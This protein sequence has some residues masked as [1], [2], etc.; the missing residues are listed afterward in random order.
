MKVKAS[1]AGALML[2]AGLFLSIAG[3]SPAKAA[4][5]ESAAASK[6]ESATSEKSTKSSSR[7]LKKKRHAY[8]K[9]PRTAVQT[10]RE[11]KELG[12]ARCRGAAGDVGIGRQRLR[13]DEF[14]RRGAGRHRGQ[15]QGD[16]TGDV[17]EGQHDPA[18]GGET[19]RPTG[20]PRPRVRRWPP[21]ISSTT[22]TRSCRRA[23]PPRPPTSQTVASQTSCLA[24]GGDGT[25]Q[26]GAAG[27]LRSGIQQ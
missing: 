8:R 22:S 3:P 13:A 5:S 27:K 19:I 21:R 12:N 20:G 1:A 16:V 14:G 11:W 10:R 18:G 7:Y 4:G 17:G 25:G 24:D 23:N 2:A 26:T 15:R 6:S 9:P